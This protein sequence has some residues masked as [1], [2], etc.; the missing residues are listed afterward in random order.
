MTSTVSAATAI[1]SKGAKRVA[2]AEVMAGAGL[3]HGGFYS[4]FRSKNALI[5]EAITHMFEALHAGFLRHTEGRTPAE[6]L[7][8]YIDVYL[9][10]SHRLD[11]AHGCP[12]AALSA[13]LPNLSDL[14]RARFT[15]GTERF[16]GGFARL[17]RSMGAKNPEALAWSAVTEMVGALAISRAVS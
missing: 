8:T 10:T 2:V 5:V 16:A 14:A 6:A 11:R 15:D 1:G 7:S 17:L 9:P 3:T 12:I 13:D 4:H